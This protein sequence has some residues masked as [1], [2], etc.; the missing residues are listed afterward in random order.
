[1]RAILWQDDENAQREL[2]NYI[3][4]FPS[5][6]T[7]GPVLLCLGPRN[8]KVGL[9]L[10]FSAVTP[11]RSTELFD[12]PGDPVPA[13]QPDL[14]SAR[15]R[16]G[17]VWHVWVEGIGLGQLYAYRVDGPYEPAKDIVSISTDSSSILCDRDFA[18]APW[19]LPAARGYDPSAREQ[20]LLSRNWTIPGRCRNASLSTN[21]STGRKTSHPGIPGRRPHLRNACS[22]LYIHQVGVTIRDLPRPDGKDSL[23]ENLGVTVWMIARAGVQ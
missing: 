9:I 14:D 23:S 19:D 13:R 16:T 21:P 3:R 5:A 12:H 4:R 2:H 22:R 11:A 10:P 7:F 20:D 18:T 15:N 1:M 6:L 17:D 8:G